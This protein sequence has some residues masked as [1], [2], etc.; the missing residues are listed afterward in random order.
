M[1]SKPL[2][3]DTSLFT[4]RLRPLTK[5]LVI[6]PDTRY[7][8]NLPPTAK[9]FLPFY[10][11]FEGLKTVCLRIRA[12]PPTSQI[13]KADDFPGEMEGGDCSMPDWK[14]FVRAFLGLKEPP[15]IRFVVRFQS[16][17][18]REIVQRVLDQVSILHRFIC[19]MC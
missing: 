8:Y 6:V 14:E 10:L 19:F 9:D 4:P 7:R 15:Q 11:R 1:A 12:F 18:T 5:N 2:I 13:A 3:P 16:R 17:V